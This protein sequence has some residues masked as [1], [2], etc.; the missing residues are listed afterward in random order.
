MPKLQT[1]RQ[2]KIRYE[3]IAR[4]EG[5]QCLICWIEDRVRRGP[6]R[7]KLIIEHADNDETN[8][9]WSNLHLCCYSHN[10]K[11]EQLT[12]EAKKK[13]IRG[14][15]DQLERERERAGLPTWGDVLKD[16]IP[17][18]SG[19]PEMKAHKRFERIW[20]R[21]VRQ[22]LNRHGSY[23]K[24][25]LLREAAKVSRCSI[26]TSRNYLEKYTSELEGPFKE[27][28]DDDGEKIITYLHPL[29][30]GPAGKEKK[31]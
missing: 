27:T 30:P 31:R 12:S 13:L 18:E 25:E 22:Q 21:W 15:S 19:S 4:A 6:P 26:Q 14:Y 8:W 28:F 9:S 17:Y 5:D 10:K 2:R 1:N 11:M 20:L 3:T 24:R 16:M 23:D 29:A 7:K